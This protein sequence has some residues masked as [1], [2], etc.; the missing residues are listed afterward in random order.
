MLFD[1]RVQQ[2][3]PRVGREGMVAGAQLVQDDAE[4]EDVRGTVDLI[5]P[6]LLGRHV[7]DRPDEEAG[8]RRLGGLGRRQAAGQAEVEQLDVAI[9]RPP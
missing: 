6:R 5:A 1:D 9:G 2:A 7:A 4:R 8:L 3:N